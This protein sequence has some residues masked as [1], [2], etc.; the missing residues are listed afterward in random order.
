MYKVI[1]AFTDLQDNNHV[2]FT[3][4]E[5]PRKGVKADVKRIKELAS[6]QNKLGHALIKAV[7]EKNDVEH[8]LDKEPPKKPVKSR[9]KA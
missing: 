7:E 6:A 5:F 2:Y 8:V 4:D 9:K 3:G 1:Q